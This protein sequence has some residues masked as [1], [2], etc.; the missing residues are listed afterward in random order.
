MFAYY[1]LTAKYTEQYQKEASKQIRKKAKKYISL[2]VPGLFEAG[3][4]MDLIDFHIKKCY[5]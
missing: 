2:K 4:K 1:I 5:F 3:I